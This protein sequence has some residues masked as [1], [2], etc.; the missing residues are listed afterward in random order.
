MAFMQNSNYLKGNVMIVK[1]MNYF[2][3]GY[4]CAGTTANL[5]SGSTLS[6]IT[7][8]AFYHNKVN[9]QYLSTATR[10]ND[11]QY[12]NDIGARKNVYLPIDQNRN[13]DV[14]G[15]SWENLVSMH[16]ESKIIS[17]EEAIPMR[18]TLESHQKILLLVRHGEAY[19]NVTDQPIPDPDLTPKGIGQSLDVSR[20]TA[21]FCNEKTKLIPDLVVVSPLKRATQ[22]ALL[23]FPYI[24]P[25]AN[26]WG[27]IPWICHP[28]VIERSNGT[29]S[30]IPSKATEL[31]NLF[32]GIDYSLL[33]GSNR[34]LEDAVHMNRRTK[35]FMRWLQGRNEEVV[36][37]ASHSNW[38]ESFCKNELKLESF[39]TSPFK[40]G[41]M[42]AIIANF[43][44]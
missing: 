37:I 8:T 33:E 25:E 44:L 20:L 27:N 41:E 5:F 28:D 42:R 18:K 31:M 16:D 32:R 39:G 7:N 35:S 2:S 43:D 40:A 12:Y 30:D 14:L 17:L 36:V 13:T 34:L 29:L 24:S 22:T 10:R 1:G 38:L 6:P 19:H 23:A 3:R 15:S 26:M 9:A 11:L 21:K 4:C